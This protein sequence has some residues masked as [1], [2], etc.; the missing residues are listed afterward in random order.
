LTTQTIAARSGGGSTTTQLLKLSSTK[1]KFKQITAFSWCKITET[2]P[3]IVT[4]TG[5]GT[6][7]QAIV[8]GISYSIN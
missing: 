6:S 3:P 1:L 7:Q 5:T 2:N 4:L 8:N